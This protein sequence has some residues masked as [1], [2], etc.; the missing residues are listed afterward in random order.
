MI[1]CLKFALYVHPKMKPNIGKKRE[2]DCDGVHAKENK[3]LMEYKVFERQLYTKQTLSTFWSNQNGKCFVFYSF[4]LWREKI[5]LTSA[6]NGIIFPS[7]KILP[8]NG[9]R[10]RERKWIKY[11]KIEKYMYKSAA[12]KTNHRLVSG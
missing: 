12:Y 10:E 8:R 7:T 11:L 2:K 4:Y 9:A 1:I 3:Q 6:K 5:E